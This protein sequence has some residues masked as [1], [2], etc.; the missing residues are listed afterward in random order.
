MKA[1]MQEI[2]VVCS[3]CKTK[4]TFLSTEKS[5][6]VEICSK[7]HPFFTGKQ[8]LVDTDNR[9]QMY[10]AR[11]EKRSESPVLS[12]KNKLLK[13]K[14]LEPQRANPQKLTLKDMLSSIK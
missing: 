3:S 14:K 4:H 6:H 13:K 10:K 8:V 12:K 11:L 1:E 2:T 5:I 7:C 9:L